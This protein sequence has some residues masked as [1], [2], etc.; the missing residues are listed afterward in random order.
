MTKK[1]ALAAVT[2]ISLGFTAVAPASA[3][4][5]GGGFSPTTPPPEPVPEP[6][7]IL[8]SLAVGGGIVAKKIAD[9][10]KG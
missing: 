7:T 6:L 10:K 5:G 1:I 4:F 3:S 9:A 8:G 2:A